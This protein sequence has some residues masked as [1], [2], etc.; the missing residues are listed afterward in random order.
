MVLDRTAEL[1]AASAQE[2]LA[3]H[4]DLIF[5][6]HG[7]YIAYGEYV[8]LL[9]M[10]D[11]DIAQGNCYRASCF[12]VDL[13]ENEAFGGENMHVIA[14]S[15]GEAFH[16]ALAMSVDDNWYI[17][18]FTARQFDE[19][20]PFPYIA[21]QDEWKREIDNALASFTGY[22]QDASDPDSFQEAD[23]WD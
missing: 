20:L 12:V 9:Q 17:V 5:L 10:A 14:I 19:N 7:D 13:L 23:Y 6:N 2:F 18:D 22:C 16:A 8:N 1:I 21:T 3:E 11:G 15:D 4:G